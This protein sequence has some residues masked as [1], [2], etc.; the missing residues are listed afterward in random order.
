M[1]L[2]NGF[3]IPLFSPHEKTSKLENR[4]RGKK[5]VMDVPVK[6]YKI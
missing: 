4:H 3:E 1:L 5:I 6:N 2:V